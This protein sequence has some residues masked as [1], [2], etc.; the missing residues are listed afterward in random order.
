MKEVIF[1]EYERIQYNY[2]VCLLGFKAICEY[3]K[4]IENPSK[5]IMV[6]G[7]I[8]EK[9]LD[10]LEDAPTEVNTDGK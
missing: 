7:D 1:S 8:I 5:D 3:C 10:G 4:D 9:A 2:N 6:I